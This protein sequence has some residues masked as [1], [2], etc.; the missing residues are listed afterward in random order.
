MAYSTR[1]Y[2]RSYLSGGGGM[3]PGVKM[4]LIVNIAVFLLQSVTGGS[5]GG[6]FPFLALRPADVVGS[7]FVWQLGTY[8]FLH[9]SLWHIL[10]NMLSLWWFGRDLEQT[11][12]TRRFLRFYF[13]C[14]VGAGV[15][16][17][18]VNY[19]F[20]SP[21]I[22]TIGASG[23]IYGV[24]MA[25]AI[26]WPDRIILFILFPMKMKYFVMIVGAISF[27]SS[28]NPNSGVSDIAHLSG[29]AIG[30]LYLKSPRVRGFDPLASL[31]G[32]YRSWKLARAKKKFQVYLR[33]QGSE[34]GKQG[35]GR[36]R[37]VH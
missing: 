28:F 13:M 21:N 11:W 18:L 6:L 22:A 4:L 24:L 25:S 34:R 32:G 2:A 1:S 27:Y 31:Q 16:V 19:L 33:K 8:L 5:L 37:T 3:P 17:V 30:Y 15:F 20:G 7:F 12:G 10:W 29:L 14:G 26:L 35:S 23:A 36:D 9:G